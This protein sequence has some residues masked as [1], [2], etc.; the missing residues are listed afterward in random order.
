[1]TDEV[2]AQLG[3]I[4]DDI[5]PVDD[6]ERILPYMMACLNEN[7]RMN[8][9]FTMPLERK[10]V[11]KEGFMIEGHVVPEGVRIRS[12]HVLHELTTNNRQLSSV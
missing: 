9:V 11:A 1:M 3:S 2:D 6:L 8:S 10:V 5:V 4:T 7:F 12:L